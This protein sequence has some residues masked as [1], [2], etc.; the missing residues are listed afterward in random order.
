MQQCAYMWKSS[1]GSFWSPAVLCTFV[2]KSPSHPKMINVHK[3]FH[4]HLATKWLSPFMITSTVNVYYL[5]CQN[6]ALF[7]QLVISSRVEDLCSNGFVCVPDC[8]SVTSVSFLDCTSSFC[9]S[10]STVDLMLAKHPSNSSSIYSRVAFFHALDIS[11][12]RRLLKTPKLA[13]YFFADALKCCS[14]K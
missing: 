6:L 8:E 2:K 5:L 9:L 11:L 4:P 3:C 14:S 12:S 7:F 1:E 10:K 13:I